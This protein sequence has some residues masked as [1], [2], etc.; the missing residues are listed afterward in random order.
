MKSK[1]I[2]RKEKLKREKRDLGS[3][4]GGDLPQKKIAKHKRIT[5]QPKTKR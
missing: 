3:L 5:P 1:K 2:A 4:Q